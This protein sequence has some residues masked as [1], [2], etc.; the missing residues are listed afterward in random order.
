MVALHRTIH[1]APGAHLSDM[2][3]RLTFNIGRAEVLGRTRQ[4]RLLERLIALPGG[5]RFC[6]GD[7]HPFNILGK[8]GAATIVDWLDATCGPPAADV[9]RTHLLLRAGAP[10]L[11]DVYVSAYAEAA[12]VASDSIL[13]WLPVI[14]AARVV[15]NVPDE[16]EALIALADTA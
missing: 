1:A 16:V 9:C 11:A 13:A 2:R 5:D 7:F 3:T 10:Q 12:G 14:A 6:H 4:Q 8:P 15:E